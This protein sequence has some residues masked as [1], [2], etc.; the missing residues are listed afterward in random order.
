MH[1][2]R[3]IVFLLWT[4]ALASCASTRD[5]APLIAG[6]HQDARLSLEAGSAELEAPEWKLEEAPRT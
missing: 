6:E 3:S 4:L 1:A 2:A 5:L